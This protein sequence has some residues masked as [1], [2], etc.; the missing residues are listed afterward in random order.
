MKYLFLFFFA[1]F[2]NSNAHAVAAQCT[3]DKD[4]TYKWC[5]CLNT[6]DTPVLDG[7]NC[8]SIPPVPPIEI[9]GECNSEFDSYNIGGRVVCFRKCEPPAQR[10]FH[11]ETGEPLNSC[12]VVC[13]EKGDYRWSYNVDLRSC[14]YTCFSSEEMIDG[15]CRSKCEANEVRNPITKQCQVPEPEPEPE[16]EEC[17]GSV[18][19]SIQC[20]KIKVSNS[21]SDLKN[22]F[23]GGFES[24]NDLLTQLL[25]KLDSDNPNDPDQSQPDI[26]PSELNQE[27]PFID[28]NSRSIIEDSFQSNPS[29]PSDN[30]IVFWGNTYSFSYARLCD[31]LETIGYFLMA[32]AYAFAAFIIVRKS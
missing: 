13:G 29:C 27:T 10:D 2:I 3:T 11:Y 28:L 1:L 15:V 7:D 18:V 25:E 16:P 5:T 6:P 12:N 19:E 32:L 31:P 30:T 8:V 26:D 23:T 14:V 21:L 4:N 17:E 20:L 22:N 24:F 9:Q